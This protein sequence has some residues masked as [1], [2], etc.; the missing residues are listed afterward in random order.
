MDYRQTVSNIKDFLN[1]SNLTDTETARELYYAYLALNKSACARLNECELLL[2]KHDKYAA[3]AVAQQQP[4]LFALLDDIMFPQ[5]ELLKRL[6][7]FYD[8]TPL[9]E[10]YPERILRI[11]GE[12]SGTKAFLPLVAEY[13]NIAGQ[14]NLRKEISLLKAIIEQDKNESKWQ[15]LLRSVEERYAYQ[16]IFDAKKAISVKD[17]PLLMILHDELMKIVPNVSVPE[18]DFS[19]ITLA[20][21]KFLT[22]EDARHIDFLLDN[23][24]KAYAARDV[25]AIENAL[26][27]WDFYRKQNKA[28]LN[29]T[30]LQLYNDASA[31]VAQEKMRHTAQTTFKKHCTELSESV[32]NC[33]PAGVVRKHLEFLQNSNFNIPEELLVKVEE[34]LKKRLEQ[35][36]AYSQ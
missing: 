4:E 34:Y 36:V 16:L 21:K 15:I 18:S 2:Q 7:F 24:R 10:I 1:S 17:Y 14:G 20:V 27:A 11:K 8:W 29:P 12:V 25:S 13:Q 22:N 3:M 26:I 33:V 32:D 19:D 6:A 23:L 28:V 9:E 30:D 35:G 5:R 31:F